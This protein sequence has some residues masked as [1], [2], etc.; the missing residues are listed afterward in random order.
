MRLIGL[1]RANITIAAN[2]ARVRPDHV[3]GLLMTQAQHAQADIDSWMRMMRAASVGH[4][5]D[6]YKRGDFDHFPAEI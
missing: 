3:R 4:M 6:A 2:Y 1:L 5:L